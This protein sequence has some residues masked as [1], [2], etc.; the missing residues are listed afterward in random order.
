MAEKDML[1]WFWKFLELLCQPCIWLFF[2]SCDLSRQA[3]CVI[4]VGHHGVC[5]NGA[6]RVV[7][8]RFGG[9]F[10]GPIHEWRPTKARTQTWQ[11]TLS[12]QV[13]L[14]WATLRGLPTSCSPPIKMPMHDVRVARQ[15]SDL[16]KRAISI[17]ERIKPKLCGTQ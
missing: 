8:H 4:Q 11:L 6:W 2:K 1:C 17:V 13:A 5:N 15:T 14:H 12:R 9:D 3:A 10:R 7:L 16:L